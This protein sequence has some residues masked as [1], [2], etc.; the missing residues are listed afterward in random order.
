[1]KRLQNPKHLDCPWEKDLSQGRQFPVGNFLLY[2][3]FNYR[4]RLR[5]AWG[6]EGGDASSKHS[7]SAGCYRA[8]TALGLKS[9][10]AGSV[11][12]LRMQRKSSSSLLTLLFATCR[13]Y[14]EPAFI[15]IPP[16]EKGWLYGHV[17]PDRERDIQVPCITLRVA[18]LVPSLLANSQ[19]QTLVIG[20]DVGGIQCMSSSGPPVLLQW[21]HTETGARRS[22]LQKATLLHKR[23]G[24]LTQLLWK[25]P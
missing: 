21:L 18:G 3:I 9:L 8:S 20:K 16:R 6:T 7:N 15:S 24:C 4:D 5:R 14:D 1:V 23:K 10:R 13:T 22:V 2:L 19:L 25:P 17:S 11:S 12:L